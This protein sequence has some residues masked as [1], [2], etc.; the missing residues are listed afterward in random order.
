MLATSLPVTE[1]LSG[2]IFTSEA[3]FAY[4]LSDF[5]LATIY[6]TFGRTTDACKATILIF[7]GHIDRRIEPHGG[8]H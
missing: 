3:R 2:S 4:R 1:L 5:R 6:A 7:S 8:N